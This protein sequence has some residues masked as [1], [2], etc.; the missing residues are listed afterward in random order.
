M[1]RRTNADDRMGDP[2]VNVQSDDDVL[3]DLI[4]SD[5]AIAITDEGSVTVRARC[6]EGAD[7]GC[8]ERMR[9]IVEALGDV[10]PELPR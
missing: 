10:P 2:V 1:T 5:F 6:P 4:D 7:A 8:A 9:F 3:G